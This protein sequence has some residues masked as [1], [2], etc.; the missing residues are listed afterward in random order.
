MPMEWVAT[1][2]GDILRESPRLPRSSLADPAL[3]DTGGATYPSIQ[4]PMA[5]KPWGRFFEFEMLMVQP[6]AEILL[7]RPRPGSF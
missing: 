4:A 1:H 6:S 2:Q 5:C 7:G 3:G